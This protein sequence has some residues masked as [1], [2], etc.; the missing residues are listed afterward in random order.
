MS[1]PQ[2]VNALRSTASLHGGSAAIWGATGFAFIKMHLG[3]SFASALKAPLIL[4]NTYPF[5]N[6]FIA[7]PTNSC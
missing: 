1:T 3:H 6:S 7:R 5:L 2:C 4:S